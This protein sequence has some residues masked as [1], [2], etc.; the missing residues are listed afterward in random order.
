MCHAGM[1]WSG[2]PGKDDFLICAIAAME[3]PQ[4][5]SEECAE[6][7]RTLS[8]KQS[9]E[10]HARDRSEA[11]NH[12]VLQTA[13]SAGIHFGVL[14]INKLKVSPD[15]FSYEQTAIA[16]FG[17]FT[18]RYQ[19]KQLWY[20]REIQGRTT[21]QAFHTKLQRINQATYPKSTFKARCRSS[22]KSDFIQAAD[23]VAYLQH[24][25]LRHAIRDARL[26]ELA[27]QVLNSG[28]NVWIKREG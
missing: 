17:V 20:D 23:C 24:R 11:E 16:L 14:T 13:V 28:K 1:D 22:N 10:F 18:T 4:A 26:K 8:M 25:L 27:L 19:I 3:N 7:K 6:L 12:A 5:W 9:A 2:K 15:L 21:E